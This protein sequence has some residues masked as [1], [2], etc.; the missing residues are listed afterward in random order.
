M[1]PF[2]LHIVTQAITNLQDGG[3]YTPCVRNMPE[4]CKIDSLAF[5]Q[6]HNMNCLV[7]LSTLPRP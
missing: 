1:P 4:F 6:H 3:N 2:Q 5:R 7:V